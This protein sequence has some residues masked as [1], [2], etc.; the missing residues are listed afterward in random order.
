MD[1]TNDSRTDDV[2]VKLVTLHQRL[3]AVGREKEALGVLTAA[4]MLGYDG[5]AFMAASDRLAKER[6]DDKK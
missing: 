2:L 5:A 3:R 4:M 1:F 6:G